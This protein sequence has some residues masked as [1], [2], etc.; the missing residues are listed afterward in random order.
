VERIRKDIQ[1]GLNP[2]NGS[3]FLSVEIGG[4]NIGIGGQIRAIMQVMGAV[5]STFTP[6][7]K[8]FKDLIS[9]DLYENPILQYLSYRGAV[10]VNAFR[11]VL[12]GAFGVDAQP[13][14]KVDSKPDIAWHLFENSLPFALQG[15][16]EGDN[17]WGIATGM[18][19]LRTSPQSGNQE[20]IERYKNYWDS[21]SIQEREK[22]G[23]LKSAY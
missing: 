17:A 13:F 8:D 16:M 20:M 12:E 19:G 15:A 6:A 3:K 5:G 9:D 21:L 22:Y 7:G 4:Q 2:L 1:Q 11:T 23:M 10:G 14:D 18:L